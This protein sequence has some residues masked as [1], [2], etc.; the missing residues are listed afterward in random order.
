MLSEQVASPS[1]RAFCHRD[2]C[3]DD[4]EENNIFLFF[5]P[6]VYCRFTTNTALRS[7]TNWEE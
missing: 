1:Q 4:G 3:E 5:K 6:G 7:A 2:H